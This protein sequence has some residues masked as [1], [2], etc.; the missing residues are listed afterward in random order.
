MPRVRTWFS[1][2]PDGVTVRLPAHVREIIGDLT[3]AVLELLPAETDPVFPPAESPGVP[4]D[5]AV[6]RL[7]PDGYG[8]PGAARDAAAARAAAEFRRLTQGDLRA[9]KAADAQKVRETLAA[10]TLPAADAEQWARALNDVRLVLGSRLGLRRDGDA[11]ALAETGEG[12]QLLALF[13]LL[14][15]VQDELLEALEDGGH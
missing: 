15:A 7:F 4:P 2:T 8:A 12:G 10:K 9:T 6:L 3:E 1:A 11:E 5:V 14:G 13:G